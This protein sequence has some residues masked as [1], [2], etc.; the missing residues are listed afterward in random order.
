MRKYDLTINSN[1]YEVVVKKVTEAEALV[2]VNPTDAVMIGIKDGDTVRVSSRRGTVVLR[3]HVSQKTNPGVVFIPFH[4]SEAAANL[5][6][7]DALDPEARIPE[8]KACS[9]SI[10][11]TTED[12]L[13]NPDARTLRGR[14]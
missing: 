8:F 12:Q 7:I 13:L 4:F 10:T 2:E 11:R 6:T 14:K 3:A 5:L 1:K 9:V